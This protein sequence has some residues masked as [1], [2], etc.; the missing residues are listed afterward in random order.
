MQRQKQCKDKNNAKTRTMQRQEQCKD[1]NNAKTRTMQRQENN[2][3]TR[4]K[5]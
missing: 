1:K 3:K 2:A 5:K 4:K